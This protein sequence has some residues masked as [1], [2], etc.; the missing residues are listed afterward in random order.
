[1]D[2][3]MRL[4]SGHDWATFTFT[5]PF[6]SMMQISLFL[7]IHLL[8]WKL[9]ILFSYLFPLKLTFILNF[10]IFK[11]YQSLYFPLEQFWGRG[12]ESF[13]SV[14]QP[15]PTSLL[16]SCSV[17]SDSATHAL[18][19]TS[20]PCPSLS[21]GARS[22]SCPLSQWY[23]PT[24]SSSVAPFSFCPQ[25]FPAA[26]SFPISW[27]FELGG[28]TIAASASASVLP[29]NIQ[30]WFPL[31]LTGSISLLSKGCSRVFS[32][33]CNS[34]A[35]IL[36]HSAFLSYNSNISTWLLEKPWRS[37]AK[38]LSRAQLFATP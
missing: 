9:Y 2:F 5:F 23:H 13:N 21:P 7:F 29:K 6:C 14:P 31:E 17:V 38:S 1:M 32:Q 30:G 10:I 18:Q 35:L 34:K 33:H 12:L 37:E 15:L 28:Q 4:Q 3:S 20:L 36:Q 22:N 19:H 27:L 16:F 26:S 24:I 25:S 11:V 8:F